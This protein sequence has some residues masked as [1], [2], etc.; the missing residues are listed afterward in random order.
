MHRVY[1]ASSMHIHSL[2]HIPCS[3]REVV[4]QIHNLCIKADFECG[5][6]T[7]I[8]T[9]TPR[10]QNDKRKAENKKD[11]C[12]NLCADLFFVVFL[13]LDNLLALGRRGLG[14]LRRP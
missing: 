12:V 13:L 1:L 11:Y 3:T 8:I 10:K 4:E 5:V 2:D 14:P 9:N 6:S 7:N